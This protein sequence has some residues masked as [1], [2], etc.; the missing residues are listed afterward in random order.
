[1]EEQMNKAI[2]LDKI[3]A[4]YDEFERVLAPL[5]ESQMTTTGV[6]DGWSIKDIL[7]HITSWQKRTVERLS[8]AKRNGRPAHQP[9]SNEEEMD[10]VNAQFYQANKDR[11]L[12][13]VLSDYRT[14]HAQLLE[15]VQGTSE[16]DLFN[17]QKFAWTEGSPLWQ[18]VAGNTYEHI[19]E[20]YGPIQ[21]WLAK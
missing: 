21:Q 10:R 18:N 20:H 4:R 1:M 3:R 17:A 9:V 16:D 7:A 15:T 12:A 2:L 19:D 11:P 5:N 6:M 13:E 8:A 14:T